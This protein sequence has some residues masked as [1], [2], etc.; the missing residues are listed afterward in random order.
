MK[1]MAGYSRLELEYAKFTGKNYA[2][3]VNSGTSALHLALLVMGVGAGDEV[4]VPDF[5]MAACGF[6]VSYCGANVVTVDCKDDLTIDEKLI[7]AK[8]TKKTKAIM[9]VHIYGRLCNMK[10]INKIAKKYKLKVIE[11]A[12]E[13]QG[14]D[15]GNADITCYSLYQNK[16]I[17]GEEG[18]IITT[19]NKKI[20]DKLQDLKCMSFGKKHNFFH[21]D[22][23]FNYR[24]TEHSALLALKSLKEVKKNLKNRRF[25]ELIFDQIT[26]E[27]WRMPKRDVVWVY[28][29]VPPKEFKPTREYREF[30]KPLSKM[31]MWRQNTGKKAKYY[32]ERGIYYPI[33]V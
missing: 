24:I 3:A 27:E 11:D 31:P 18:G 7:E 32:G 13:A 1:K 14:A 20:Y 8:I 33:K 26:P 23:G 5:T 25:K 2:V 28:D 21:E 10:A 16:I 22:I 4:I 30:F 15:T 6:A 17:A 29:F 9:P 19:N 12:C